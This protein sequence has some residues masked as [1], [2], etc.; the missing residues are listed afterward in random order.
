MSEWRGNN[1]ALIRVLA[2]AQVAVT[3]AIYWFGLEQPLSPLRRLLYV[4]PGVPVFFFIS[5]LLVTRSFLSTSPAE[6]VR[7]RSLRIFPALWVCLVLMLLPIFFNA[8]CSTPSTS[9][10]WLAWWFAQLSFGQMWTPEFLRGCWQY[11]FNGG[12]WTVAVELEFYALLPLLLMLAGKSARRAT[13]VLVTLAVASLLAQAW[14]ISQSSPLMGILHTTVVPYLWIF[15][16]GMLAQRHFERITPWFAGKLAWWIAGFACVTWLA[17]ESGWR[18]GGSDINPLSMLALCAL[19]M[20]TALSA[21]GLA[22]RMLRGHDLTYGLYLLHP[23]VFLLMTTAGLGS[24]IANAALALTLS[25]GAAALSWLFVERPF[26][27]RKHLS[28]QPEVA[29]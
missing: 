14:L 17:R 24:G 1:F 6:Y 18:T 23:L 2:S 28:A 7:N 8:G 4:F 15:A 19:V 21:R 10:Q 3:H 13:A 16:L 27:K 26:L 11:S 22:D 5:G 25:A 9:G 29:P 20:S 12:R